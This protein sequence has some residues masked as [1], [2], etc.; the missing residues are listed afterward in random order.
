M[1]F[2]TRMR[3]MKMMFL[4]VNIQPSS[5]PAFAGAGSVGHLPPRMREKEVQNRALACLIQ[6]MSR[7]IVIHSFWE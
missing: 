4:I 2:R 3:L 5:A 6:M 7:N 1:S